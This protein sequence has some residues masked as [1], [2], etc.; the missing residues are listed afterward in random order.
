MSN[1][2]ECRPYGDCHNNPWHPSWK[3]IFVLVVS[4]PCTTLN[5]RTWFLLWNYLI[6]LVLTF[7][8][9]FIYLF[10]CIL[11]H[12]HCAPSILWHWILFSQYSKL[13]VIGFWLPF[14]SLALVLAWALPSTTLVMSLRGIMFVYERL[15]IWQGWLCNTHGSLWCFVTL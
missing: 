5:A 14:G 2:E 15:K 8:L 10:F 12:Q 6:H 1:R 11:A 9:W 4:I 13:L 3:G 7:V